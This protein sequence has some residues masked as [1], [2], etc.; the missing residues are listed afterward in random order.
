MF[1]IKSNQNPSLLPQPKT[2]KNK[3]LPK[4]FLIRLLKLR[5]P[6]HHTL[7][8][9]Y[10]LIIPL[11]RAHRHKTHLLTIPLLKTPLTA[12]PPK[13]E[14][15]YQKG[16][17]FL[18]QALE[19]NQSDQRKYLLRALFKATSIN[20]K[21]V[22]DQRNLSG[23]RCFFTGYT[24]SAYKDGLCPCRWQMGWSW[25]IFP[26]TVVR[27]GSLR[28]IHPMIRGSVSRFSVS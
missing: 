9:I 14:N 16:K 7:R 18:C 11:R 13:G 20:G 8:P 23:Q 21:L 12:T 4:A 27:S 5:W 24:Y 17:S 15:P 2:N 3:A 6:H 25:P 26:W 1:W 28:F 19:C 10:P 22:E